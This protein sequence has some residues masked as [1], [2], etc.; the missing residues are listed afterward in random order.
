LVEDNTNNLNMEKFRVHVMASMYE[1]KAAVVLFH[2]RPETLLS[3]RVLASR[4]EFE[5]WFK[6]GSYKNPP[7]DIILGTPQQKV[8]AL[9]IYHSS[10]NKDDEVDIEKHPIKMGF[11]HGNFLYTEM[12][13][14]LKEFQGSQIDAALRHQDSNVINLQYHSDL[15]KCMDKVMCVVG[16]VDQ[17]S[18]HPENKEKLAINPQQDYVGL[19]RRIKDVY[20]KDNIDV[21]YLDGICHHDLLFDFKIDTDWVPTAMVFW[22]YKKEFAIMEDSYTYEHIDLFIKKAKRR[23]VKIHKLPRDWV[24][25]KRNC[26]QYKQQV[27]DWQKK[28]AQKVLESQNT[29]EEL[30]AENRETGRDEIKTKDYSGKKKKKGSHWADSD[31]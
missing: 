9:V 18:S 30:V 23:A 11:F 24:M 7:D 2:D 14:F 28:E 8:P 6:F 10:F 17:D 12:H 25:H 21:W 1:Y 15:D 13:K 4:P 3:Y 27:L 16:V 5:E 29:K 31:L 20:K 26:A 22:W 19:L